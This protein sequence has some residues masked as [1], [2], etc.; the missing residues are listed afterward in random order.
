MQ[1]VIEL[2]K[3]ELIKINNLQEA[4]RNNPLVKEEDI[5]KLMWTK[6]KIDMALYVL[7][8]GKDG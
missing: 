1:Q 7:E 4:A 8:E 5:R 3:E 6:R 2:L